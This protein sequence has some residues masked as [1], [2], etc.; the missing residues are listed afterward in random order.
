MST[1][2]HELQLTDDMQRQFESGLAKVRYELQKNLNELDPLQKGRLQ[3][4]L[5]VFSQRLVIF[6]HDFLEYLARAKGGAKYATQTFTFQTPDPKQ[7]PEIASSLL[8]GA[9][10]S[11]LLVFIPA[12]TTGHLWWAASIGFGSVIAGALGWP[13]WLVVAL[14]SVGGGAGV[15]V[16]VRKVL[17]GKRRNQIR[18]AVLKWFD[19]HVTPQLREWSHERI[20]D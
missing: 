20:E 14:L 3:S 5:E 11:L 19:T 1:D 6:Q 8:A 18:Q 17:A 4:M 7:I 2:K 9:T 12:G 10:G 16:G 13:V 15:F